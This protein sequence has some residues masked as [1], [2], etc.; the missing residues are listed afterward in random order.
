MMN[1]EIIYGRIADALLCDYSSV[2]YVDAI[3]NEYVSYA[4]D[5]EFRSLKT[6][7][8]GK[9][10]FNDLKKDAKV[11]V[12]EEDQH[13][14]TEDLQKENLMKMMKNKTMENIVYRL[15]IGGKPVYHSLRMIRGASSNDEFFIL[16]VTNV[17]KEVRTELEAKRLSKEKR[18]YNQIA[19]SLASYYNT[20][21]YVD[22]ENET[23]MEFSAKTEYDEL[24][25]PKRG[26]DFFG[27]SRKNS[28][29]LIHND[30][31]ERLLEVM[32]KEYI[33]KKLKE[34]K[35]FS[36]RY[37]LLL[38]GEFKYTKLTAMWSSDRTH[39]IIG[40]ENIDEQIR[41]ELAN[42]ELEK[43]S[44]TI[45]QILNSLAYRYDAIFYVDIETGAY[46]KYGASGESG[47]LKHDY[48]GDDFF[49][50][51]PQK[52]KNAVF[53]KDQEKLEEAVD[54]NILLER[55]THSDSFTLTY[56]Q[57][58]NNTYQYV[59]L[60][61]AWAEDRRHVI[62]G[63]ANIDEDMRRENKYKRELMSVTEKAMNDELTGV[64]NKNAYKESESALQNDI[65]NGS[66]KP[67]AL[68]ICDLNDLKI[69]NDTLGHKAGDEYICAAC[70]LICNI[71]VHSPV[72]RIGGD[73]FA[74]I[75]REKD[76]SRKEE[77]LSELRRQVLENCGK[78]NSPVLASGL[79]EFEPGLHK[80]VSEVFELAD[81]R[82]YEN[83][84]ELKQL[85][86]R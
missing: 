2:Y 4:L 56:K 41:R 31:R 30:D 65:D 60:R 40:V 48:S 11:V 76:Y 24:D 84:K 22:A 27:E 77:L 49:H 75:L 58:I 81:S 74:V 66:I 35:I 62:L 39:F 63:I 43:K 47:A 29:R 21:Y 80:K 42:K 82:M 50:E 57:L 9:D 12:W 44:I 14:F 79:A 18:I 83:K 53:E 15:M 1:T 32:H 34:Q 23:Y 17:D 3:T 78:Q 71:F 70:R 72:F 13:I 67:F 54:K 5:P 28:M 73:E 19:Q 51:A 8:E 61:V 69:I 38:G 85:K 64:K 68:L 20:I 33:T 52:I 59:S 6:S 36:V 55:L 26:S 37:R 25:I 45:T 7:F 46:S 16:G 86:H 10:F